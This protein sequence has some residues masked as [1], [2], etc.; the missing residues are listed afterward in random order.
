ML[1]N[2]TCAAVNPVGTGFFGHQTFDVL[3]PP[4]FIR[5]LPQTTG[6]LADESLVNLTC[7]VEC[8]PQCAIHWLKNGV[9]ITD[10]DVR[11]NITTRHVGANVE[12]FVFDSVISNLLWNMDAWPDKRLTRG[13]DNAFYSCLTSENVAGGSVTSTTYF[14]VEYPPED[15]DV[16]PYEVNVTENHIPP[17]IHCSA[18]GFPE[19]TYIWTTLSENGTKNVV[20]GNQTLRLNFPILRNQSG[21]YLCEASNKY[22][23]INETAF[24]DV[25]YEPECEVTKDIEQHGLF[26]IECSILSAN[27][28]DFVYEWLFEDGN[29]TEH[30]KNEGNRLTFK[31]I[32]GNYYVYGNYTCTVSNSIGN[33]TCSKIITSEGSWLEKVAKSK[34]ILMWAAVIAALLLVVALVVLFFLCRR[35]SATEGKKLS[36][37][38]RQNPEGTQTDISQIM[39]PPA[40]SFKKREP[41]NRLTRVKYTKNDGSTPADA[42]KKKASLPRDDKAFYE[43]LP[44]HGLQPPPNK[45]F[46][47]V[48][49]DLEYADVEFGNQSLNNNAPPYTKAKIVDKIVEDS[50]K[51]PPQGGNMPARPPRAKETRK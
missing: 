41:T 50:E 28:R 46:K 13:K 33:A 32:G 17:E 48:L 8:A 11:Y 38:S 49:P 1:S 36:M 31:E 39:H 21:E 45:P 15:I 23:T 7:Q 43:N 5:A 3:V 12:A 51:E 2:F 34:D 29:I 22:G 27:P 44:F 47:P 4:H 24:I 10:K 16:S 42:K 19:P 35:K 40:V 6:V 9:H 20:S 14:R 37:E 26:I 30:V 25:L 18:S